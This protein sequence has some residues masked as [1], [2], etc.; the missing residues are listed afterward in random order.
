MSESSE[1]SVTEPVRPQPATAIEPEPKK[2]SSD[3]PSRLLS[4]G[5]LVPLVAFVFT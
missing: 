1:S 5:V 2:A 4:A 3:L